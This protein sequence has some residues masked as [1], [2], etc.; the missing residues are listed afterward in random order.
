MV[1]RTKGVIRAEG[2]RQTKT[3]NVFE[4]LDTDDKQ[5]GLCQYL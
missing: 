3:E 2:F 4:M 1:N 5:K